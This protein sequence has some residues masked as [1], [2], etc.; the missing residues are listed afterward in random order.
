MNGGDLDSQGRGDI[1]TPMAI[2]CTGP[3]VPGKGLVLQEEGPHNSRHLPGPVPRELG[4][5]W[6]G[7]TF[8]LL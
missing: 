2:C 8:G 1:G 4:R 6:P 3:R 5:A 7:L